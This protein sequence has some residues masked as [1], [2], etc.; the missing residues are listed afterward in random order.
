[1]SEDVDKGGSF[2]VT[3]IHETKRCLTSVPRTIVID[4]SRDGSC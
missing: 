1:M 3:L 2:F 4:F